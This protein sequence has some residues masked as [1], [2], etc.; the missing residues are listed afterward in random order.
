MATYKKRG[1]KAKTKEE[2]DVIVEDNSTTAEV[3]NTLDEGAGKAE[4]WVEKNQKVILGLVGIV[5][6][7]VIGYILYQKY[8]QEPKQLDASNE[9]YQAQSYY[10]QALDN[11]ADRDS[12]YNLSLTGYGGKYGSVDIA[13]KYS[14]TAAGNQATYYA[15]MAYLNLGNYQEAINYLD[16]YSGGDEITGP[17]AKGAIGDAFNQLDQPTEALKYYVE[18][19]TMKENEVTTPRFLFKAGVT[20][21]SLGNSAEAL[22]YFT[23]IMDD[24][25]DSPEAAKAGTYKGQAEAMQ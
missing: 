17:L 23:Q 8:Y 15:G 22:K 6:I 4:A 25:K 11:E 16:D 7:A 2:K 24:Y 9:M 1:Y 13:D 14:G 12:L 21:L 19:A 18:A 5:A 3:F 20:A 10:F